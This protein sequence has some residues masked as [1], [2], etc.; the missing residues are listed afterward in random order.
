M[1]E[2]KAEVFP[3]L[4]CDCAEGQHAPLV[5]ELT[6]AVRARDAFIAIAAH[7]LRNPM[8][9]ILGHI[10]YILL[11]GRRPDSGYPKAVIIALERLEGLIGEY[12]RRTTTLLDVSRITAGQFRA[13]LS[14]VALSRIMRKA[15]HR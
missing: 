8:T 6:Q 4:A 5:A 2:Y 14:V 3:H 10:Q 12:I 11:I 9:P 7:E 13:E 1:V 15:A